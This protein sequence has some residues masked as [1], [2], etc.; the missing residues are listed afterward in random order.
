M[1]FPDCAVSR[2]LVRMSMAELALAAPS[3]N[4]ALGIEARAST[5]EAHA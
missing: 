2:I 1:R 3:G 5:P 4:L